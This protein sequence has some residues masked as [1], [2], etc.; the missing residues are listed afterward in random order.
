[1]AEFTCIFHLIEK[2]KRLVYKVEMDIVSNAWI[3]NIKC[4][5]ENEIPY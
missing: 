2:K 4:W 1:L 5:D 3:F